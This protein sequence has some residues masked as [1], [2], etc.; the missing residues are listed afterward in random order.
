MSRIGLVGKSSRRDRHDAVDNP[1]L[2][3]AGAT[4]TQSTSDFDFEMILKAILVSIQVTVGPKSSK[5]V[6]MDDDCDIFG[7]VAKDTR[8]G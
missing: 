7:F 5:V 3:R 1:N 4:F 8:V 6:A 2:L